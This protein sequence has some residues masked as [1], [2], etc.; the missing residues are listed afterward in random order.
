MPNLY[1]FHFSPLNE[2]DDVSTFDCGESII[3]DFLKED[4][5]FFQQQSLS[6]TYLFW[7][8]DNNIAAFFSISTD[9]LSKKNSIFENLEN[10]VWNRIHRVI[11]LPNEKRIRQ[12]PAV[13]VGRLGVNIKY[14]K[15]GIAYQLLDFIKEFAI[16]D[17]KPACR[18]L[19]LDALNK[20]RQLK[21]YGK[22]DFVMVKSDLP[23]DKTI[24]MYYD[25]D[26]LR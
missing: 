10:A 26:R 21:Y 23:T 1:D 5:Y 20:D 12:Y 19:L 9:S 17:I 3:T 24:T 11:E 4:A 6:N 2:V 16:R 25:L 13:L 18:L 14:H 15:T 8:S 7:D 22:N